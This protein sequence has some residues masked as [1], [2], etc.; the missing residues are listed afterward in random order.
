MIDILQFSGLVAKPGHT[1]GPYV[2]TS[3]YYWASEDT[4]RSY[5]IPKPLSFAY[6]AYETHPSALP[7]LKER[8][9]RFARAGGS[10]PYDPSH[11]DPLLI[12]SYS[13]S[14]NNKER[15]LEAIA[16]ARAGYIVALT[17][18]GVPDFAH[19]TVTTPPELFKEY[20]RYMSDHHYTVLSVRDLARYVGPNNIL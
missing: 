3:G 14:G 8:G 13:T 9:Y 11:D 6:P 20:L 10:R 2:C 15:V 19:P 12:P 18:H 4:C 1:S 17:I 5:D 16:Q 7:V